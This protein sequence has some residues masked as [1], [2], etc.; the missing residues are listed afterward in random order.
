MKFSRTHQ[1]HLSNSAF[2]LANALGYHTCPE[3]GDRQLGARLTGTKERQMLMGGPE[4]TA[5]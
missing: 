3:S 1:P 4:T 5:A 2:L